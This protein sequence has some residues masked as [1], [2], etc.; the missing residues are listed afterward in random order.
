[1]R[2]YDLMNEFEA[3]ALIIYILWNTAVFYLYGAD[4]RK[5]QRG[6]W[7]ISENA[8]ILSALLMGGVG[9]LLGMNSFRHKTKHLKFRIVVPLAVVLNIAIVAAYIYMVNRM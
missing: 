4:K 7:R 6:K 2:G 3:A 5:S 9:A 8:L 1:M